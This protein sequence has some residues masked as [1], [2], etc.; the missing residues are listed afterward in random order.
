MN[1]SAL[2]IASAGPKGRTTSRI[3]QGLA[4]AGVCAIVPLG[5]HQPS[6][7]QPAFRASVD[8][9][10][11]DVVVQDKNGAF[12]SDL[13]LEDFEL[14]DEGKPQ[15]VQQL[16]LHLVDDKGRP[17]V[18]TGR[19]GS[20]PAPES[21]RVFVVVFD[22]GHLSSAAFKRAR[23]AATSLFSD[24]WLDGDLGGVVVKG[25]MANDRLTPD[26]NE[27]LKAVREA[28][29]TL[30]KTA[31]LLDEREWPRMTDVDAIRIVLNNDTM[32]Y[33]E[34]IRR[35]CGDQPDQCRG[36]TSE[37][38]SEVQSKA[39]RMAGE[40]R[41]E[42]A[43]TLQTLTVLMDG[44]GRIEGRKSVLLMSEGFIGDETWP[45]MQEAQERAARANARI[46]TLDAQGLIRGNARQSAGDAGNRG[47]LGQLLQQT[48]PAGDSLNTL[49]ADTGGFVVHNANL[50][51]TA[52]KQI[53]ADAGNYYVLGYRPAALDG[54]FHKLSVTV[55]NRPE[56]A[57]RARSGYIAAPAITTSRAL[58]PISARPI[59]PARAADAA[60]A[61]AAE[62]V[63]S[64]SAAAP[65]SDPASGGAADPD[66][67]RARPD[68]ASHVAALEKGSPPNTAATQG[69]EAFAR[70]DLATAR[71][72]LSMAAV[73]PSARPWVHYALGHA[74][75]GLGDYAK[76]ASEWERVLAA[77][78]EFEP[79]Y[80]DLADGYLRDDDHEKAARVLRQAVSR[81][82]LDAEV[83]KALGLVQASD[84]VLDDAVESFQKAITLAP[85]DA[86]VHF[87]LGKALELRYY[88]SRR[89]VEQIHG[90]MANEED[91][92]AA[93]GAY[94]RCVALGG[95]FASD[96][97]EGLTR[98]E[99]MSK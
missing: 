13:A 4:L 61:D 42:S 93:A 78:P 86:A 90:W 58:I 98:L 95:P 47:E 92:K 85:A 5:A 28:T 67:L 73:A 97:R 75:Y 32:L 11:V 46:Y 7:R 53:A 44:L 27:M 21:P 35:A 30:S 74:H 80:L 71:S 89:Y 49:A 8:I 77:S 3:A 2:F 45:L 79:V 81:W 72:S 57:V 48:D 94:E 36:D 56:L 60:R 14:L 50:F 43:E 63:S 10:E 91:R 52:V 62:R 41:A 51:G 12:A 84:G 29:P 65:G 54:K 15:R 6:P 23:D 59:E 37:A 83:F 40:A 82:P 16:Y 17:G 38:E 1:T 20:A 88:G 26:R 64:S 68:A 66:A 31:R 70:G 76:A 87:N 99:W 19:A 24:Q 55:K 69:W 25:Q 34:M 9:V 33:D 22:E 96:A 18:R 39:L